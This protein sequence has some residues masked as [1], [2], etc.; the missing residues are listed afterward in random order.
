MSRK[1]LA[2]ALV[3]SLQ[4]LSLSV[5]LQ[6][7][8]R[9]A[10]K[11]KKNATN[12]TRNTILKTEESV[13]SED[14]EN[15][16]IPAISR[17]IVNKEEYL[18][19]RAEHIAKLR[20]LPYPEPYVRNKAIYEAMRQE[21][22]N[23]ARTGEPD[24]APN[25]AW[26]FL[27]PAPIPISALTSYS[28][29]VSAIAVDPTN[30][31]IVYVCAAQGGL[32][33][34]LDGGLT[35]TPLLDN[36][37]TLAMGAV[38]VSPSDPSII[39][40]GTGEAAF[41][42]DSFLGVGVYRITN[43]NSASPVVA[44]PLNMGVGGSDVFTGRSISEIVV[45]P[46]NSNIIF[47]ST[48]QGASGV[49]NG[50][51]NPT[52]LRGV[53][54]STNALA[55]NP[56]FERLTV[57]TAVGGNRA[58]SDMAMEPGN[59]NRL[60][61][62][63]VDTG[64]NAGDAGVYFTSNALDAN[65]TF[66]RVL[67]IGDSSVNG[68]SELAI[69]KV[70]STVTVY[71]STGV[72]QGTVYKS[73]YDSNNPGT[74]SF[75]QTVANLFCTPQCWYDQAIAVD[76]TDA[77]RVYLG[78]SPR[79]VFAIS[80][81]GGTTFTQSNLG[82]HVDTHAITVA[83]SNPNI[84]YF[85][86]DGGIWKSTNGGL[87]WQ[88]LNNS[89]FSATQFQSI[90][91]HPIDRH[92]TLGGTQDNGTQFLAPDGIT[93]VQSDGGDG[94]YA[95]IDQNSPTINNV[96]AYHTY[97][98]QTNT[99]IG[100]SRATTTEPSGDPQW[101]GFLGCNNN[102]SNNG[103]ACS[104][105]VLFYAPMVLGPGTPN[106]LYFGTNKLYR[107]ANM[108]TTMTAV[109]QTLPTAISSIAISKQ[110]DNVRIVGLA[111]GGVFATSDGSTTLN[112]VTGP[113]PIRFVGR[114]AI[115]PNNANTAYVTLTGYGLAPGQ[116]V[117]KTTNLN[118]ATPTWTVAGN[119][120]PDVP[121]NAFVVDQG[122]SQQLFAGTDIGVFRSVDGGANWTSFNEG[123]PRVAVFDMDIQR[124]HRVLKIATHGRGIWEMP[125][126]VNNVRSRADF[127]GDGK[128]DF[129]VFRNGNWFVQKSTGGFQGAQWGAAGD[130]IVPGDY[131]GDGKTDYAVYR[132]TATGGTNF[133]VVLSG[134]ATFRGAN[135]GAT[136]DI[137][138]AGDFDGDGKTD[139]AVY[140]P[141]TNT[142]YA[143]P[144]NGSAP[145]IFSLGQSGD[146]P[147]VF[148]YDGDN[149]TDFGIY[150][151]SNGLWSIR[152]SSDNQIITVQFG[153]PGDQPVPAD[154][155]NDNKEDIAVFRAGTW[156]VL[157]STNGQ[158]TS[159]SWGQAGDIPA[160][161]DYDGDGQDDY[162][163]FR[164]GQWFVLRSAQGFTSVAFGA[165]GDIPI[166][167]GYIP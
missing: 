106:T 65:P 7:Q 25:L 70:G 11:S 158:I 76:P 145:I 2:A 167:S 43:A 19:L 118:A 159:T 3:L 29:R 13:E 102:N 146:T 34:T 127:D 35:W 82:L 114:V 46:T 94:G 113:I 111:G 63:L 60:F 51:G 73:T 5:P 148:D 153:A 62:S 81:N 123:L 20:G 49:G 12:E 40:V 129:A 105:S 36:A 151:P 162:A 100:F 112:D 9:S 64:N 165:T 125:L 133:F 14:E 152:R 45:H 160:P 120:I 87:N 132:A 143:L 1:I 116:H 140:R 32:Y 67:A 103:I 137:A 84:I 130:Q 55:A 131:D 57:S 99:L 122:N 28:G 138:R 59:P 95:A 142:Y 83:P 39:Y 75:T 136:G 157:R 135:W 50:G 144:T 119:G 44:G 156:I 126:V 77:N 164:A 52:P 24:A 90:A 163:V 58:I 109:S 27:G 74:P 22:A 115:D 79:V 48:T 107:S 134:T 128:T 71:A 41:S 16:D 89:T 108:G 141:S 85:G 92:Y 104:D 37:L 66:T 96:T 88:T 121:V 61:V 150:R 54:R 139:I 147:V 80:T 155:D 68:R 98:N 154:Y 93:W 33:R 110:N 26:R 97:Y 8:E 30:P 42:Q 31:N 86:S 56:L 47:V 72:A 69:N 4:L 124:V 21:N 91:L 161:G 78:G 53:Y 101:G 15:E 149:K 10:D 117:W 166:T 6:A 23:R 38:A 18:R 17:G